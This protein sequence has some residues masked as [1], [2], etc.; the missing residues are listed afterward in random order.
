MATMIMCGLGMEM[1]AAEM[2]GVVGKCRG[3]YYMGDEYSRN[4]CTQHQAIIFDDMLGCDDWCVD[5][6]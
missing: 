3:C 6:R 4:Y 1:E 5:M 2:R